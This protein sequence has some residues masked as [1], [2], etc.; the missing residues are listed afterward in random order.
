MKYEHSFKHIFPTGNVHLPVN[1]EIQKN[2][3]VRPSTSY[4]GVKRPSDSDADLISKHQRSKRT[5][6]FD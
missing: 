2:S 6:K 3:N 5:R 1:E 4:Q